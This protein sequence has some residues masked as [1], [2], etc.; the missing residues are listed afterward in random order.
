MSGR[1]FEIA[2]WPFGP[3]SFSVAKVSHNTGRIVSLWI[4]ILVTRRCTSRIDDSCVNRRLI[5][6]R[7][8]V[9][10]SS[11]RFFLASS[12]FSAS[13]INIVLHSLLLLHSEEVG[14]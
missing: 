14:D 5:S 10:G 11:G 12:L 9:I 1:G 7:L 6:N 2:F 3:A 8:G 4:E 13:S